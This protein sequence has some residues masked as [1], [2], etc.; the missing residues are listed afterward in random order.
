MLAAVAIR[1]QV[2]AVAAV[3]A[4]AGV[5]RAAT[6]SASSG[7]V[8]AT[9]TSNDRDRSFHVTIARAGYS[10]SG[11]GEIA[12]PRWMR[13]PK[14]SVTSEVRSP[15]GWST[16]SSTTDA[17]AAASSRVIRSTSST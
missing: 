5:A 1:S 14:G 4:F 9:I 17:P 8:R 2:L 7:A 12:A 3:L 13:V 16:G 15:H 11:G 6:Q 10:S